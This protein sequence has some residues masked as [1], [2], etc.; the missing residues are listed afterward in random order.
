MVRFNEQ[1]DS[2][3]LVESVYA[4]YLKGKSIRSIARR[5]NISRYAVKKLV[6]YMENLDYQQQ[7]WIYDQEN[8][9]EI[10]QI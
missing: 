6:D 1:L 8:E 2:Y 9:E 7:M 10:N 3:D 4:D 5:R